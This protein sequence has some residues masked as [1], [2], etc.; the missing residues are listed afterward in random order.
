MAAAVVI[1]APKAHIE[2]VAVNKLA[3]GILLGMTG[4]PSG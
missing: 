4:P 1:P 3:V 2:V